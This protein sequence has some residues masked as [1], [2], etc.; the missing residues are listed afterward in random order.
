MDNFDT[1]VQPG[2]P[3]HK[4]EALIRM[5]GERRPGCDINVVISVSRAPV[6]NRE[7]AELLGEFWGRS[8][9][10]VRMEGRA[11]QGW[12][13]AIERNEKRRGD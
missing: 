5:T 6:Q 13:A 4:Q 1:R 7:P 12:G 8:S 9:C 11:G 3:V 10:V 2:N